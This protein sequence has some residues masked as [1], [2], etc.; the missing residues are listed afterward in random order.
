LGKNISLG[1]RFTNTLKKSE[2]R[3]IR[4]GNNVI[5]SR[6]ERKTRGRGK[7]ESGK[8]RRT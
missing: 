2:K 5:S 3:R 6:I 7:G 8:K 1:S 4:N